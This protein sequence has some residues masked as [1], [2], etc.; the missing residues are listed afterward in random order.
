MQ[1]GG[2]VA[3][4]AYQGD[5]LA[6]LLAEQREEDLEAGGGWAADRRHRQVDAEA[7]EWPAGSRHRWAS[8]RER[9]QEAVA[10]EAAGCG[11]TPCAVPIEDGELRPSGHRRLS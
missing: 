10:A 7:E 5:Q 3:D 4:G 9:R 6:A 11:P 1:T 8:M 2:G